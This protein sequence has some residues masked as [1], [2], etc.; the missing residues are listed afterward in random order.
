MLDVLVSFL[1]YEPKAEPFEI[2]RLQ[3]FKRKGVLS[4]GDPRATLHGSDWLLPA[5]V[6]SSAVWLRTHGLSC[7]RA[8]ARPS[9]WSRSRIFWAGRCP[10]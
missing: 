5:E 6:L 3:A 10:T 9:A 1:D 4:P 7:R 8:R 2:R